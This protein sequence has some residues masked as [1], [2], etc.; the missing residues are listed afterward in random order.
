MT[1]VRPISPSAPIRSLRA[2]VPGRAPLWP[3]YT[4][5]P[6]PRASADFGG[7][8][9]QRPG[10]EAGVAKIEGI[11]LDVM[12]RAISF[13]EPRVQRRII[14][15]QI[16][17]GQHPTAIEDRYP[18]RVE[19]ELAAFRPIFADSGRGIFTLPSAR[20]PRVGI[21][22]FHLPIKR[23]VGG[24]DRVEHIMRKFV[25]E[26]RLPIIARAALPQQV[27]RRTA[28][29]APRHAAGAGVPIGTVGQP[30]DP[31]VIMLA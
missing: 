28:G 26:D 29:E 13:A 22:A 14:G 8:G 31:L 1:A 11:R 9:G 24:L 6:A 20:L 2:P 15:L 10:R 3:G 23:G 30:P 27:L 19:P 12:V 17:I 21:G 16:R 4:N 7:V 18:V 25:Q 5:W